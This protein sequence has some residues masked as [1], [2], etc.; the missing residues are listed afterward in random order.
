MASHRE[1]M[2]ASAAL[3]IRERGAHPT[4]IADVLAHSGAPR[5]SAYHYFPGGRTQLLCEAVDLAG[6]YVASQIEEAESGVDALDRLVLGFRKQLINSE[7]R[8]GCPV[9]A[10]A[11]E[12]GA[13]GDQLAPVVDRAAVAFARW[14]TLITDRLRADGVDAD[15]AEE[16]AT[17]ALTA[18][19]GAIVVARAARDV[20]PLDLVH[21]QLRA[22][23]ETATESEAER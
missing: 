3:L 18:V 9:V 1:R 7:F 4:A 14:N 15:R 20:K 8:A 16:L 2:V 23:L 19:E 5:G 21:R 6:T 13:K 11:V 10:V 12:S 22:L 17:L